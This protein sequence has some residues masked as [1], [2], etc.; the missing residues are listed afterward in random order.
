MKTVPPLAMVRR[1]SLAR[2]DARAL[3]AELTSPRATLAMRGE[4]A[5]RIPRHRTI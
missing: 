1:S 3:T 5:W 2:L 4:H